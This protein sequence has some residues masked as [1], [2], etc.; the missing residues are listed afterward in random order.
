MIA[1]TMENLFIKFFLSLKLDFTTSVWIVQ[2]QVWFFPLRASIQNSWG[3][4]V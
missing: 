2:F 4:A 3:S 1:F